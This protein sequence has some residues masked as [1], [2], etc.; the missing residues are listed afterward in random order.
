MKPSHIFTIMDTALAAREAGEVFNPMFTGE[1]GLGKSQIVQQ[2]VKRQ[3]ER[4]PNFGFIDLRIAYM[5]APDLIGLPENELSKDGSKITS[6]YQPDFW[7]REED[8]EGLILLEEPNRGTTGVMNCLMQ[9]LTDRKVHKYELPK[10]W[11]IAACINPD[12]DKYDVNTMD[13]ALKDRFEEFEIE[14]DALTFLEFMESASWDDNIQRFVGDGLWLYKTSKELGQN[15]KYISPRT[16]SKVNAAEKAGIRKNRNLHRIVVSSILGKD[17]GNE[18]HKYC[19]DQAPVTASDLIK[20]SKAALAKLR[21]HSQPDTY[22]GDMIAATV[23]SIIKAYGGLKKDCKTDQIDEELMA[24]V[25]KII[26]ADMAVQLLKGC[27]FKVTK[28]KMSDFL[29]DFVKR[30]PDLVDVLRANLKLSRATG[31]DKDAAKK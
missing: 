20:D 2:W 16:W 10:G 13:T 19:Y 27:G 9:L 26:P 3:K 30:H 15:G 21:E 1:A 4:N 14:Y 12:S 8:S 7:P 28:G 18:Y 22:K 29:N 25:A 23:E 24:D 17:I 6:H 31:V 5:E 11:L